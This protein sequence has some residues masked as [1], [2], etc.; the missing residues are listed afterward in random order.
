MTVQNEHGAPF[1]ARWEFVDDEWLLHLWQLDDL[2]Q[3][4]SGSWVSAHLARHF[5]PV[6][7]LLGL[8]ADHFGLIRIDVQFSEY[9]ESRTFQSLARAQ[10]YAAGQVGRTPAIFS[11]DFGAEYAAYQD[12]SLTVQ[13]A[14]ISDLFPCAAPQ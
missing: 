11:D 7:P 4:D 14:A 3:H 5:R 10:H 8:P 1:L 2:P 12:V 9:K 13:G 6:E